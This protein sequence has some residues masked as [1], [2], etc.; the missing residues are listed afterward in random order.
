[1]ELQSLSAMFCHLWITFFHH[2][3][4]KTDVYFILLKFLV[5]FCYYKLFQIS[6]WYFYLFYFLLTL[7]SLVYKK[8]VI[9]VILQFKSVN[10]M[11]HL[12]RVCLKVLLLNMNWKMNKPLSIRRK[13]IELH[14]NN[15]G[16]LWAR[17]PP[18]PKTFI[19]IIF[20]YPLKLKCLV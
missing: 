10:Q 12:S 6:I 11:K 13:Y 7:L 8:Y 3:A 17:D 9:I 16:E 2:V 18:P 19:V 1:M 15:D 5:I 14:R 4:C 20:N